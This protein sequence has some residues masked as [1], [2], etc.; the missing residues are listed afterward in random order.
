MEKVANDGT[1][2]LIDALVPHLTNGSAQVFRGPLKDTAGNVK[3]LETDVMNDNEIANMT[4]YVQGVEVIGNFREPQTD[5]P[6]N[7]LEIKE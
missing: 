3:Y 4:W 5:L 7:D 6:K 1:Q 2:K